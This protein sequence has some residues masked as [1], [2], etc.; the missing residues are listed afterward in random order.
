MDP[1]PLRAHYWVWIYLFFSAESQN[2]LSEGCLNFTEHLSIRE[3]KFK[4]NR[5][6]WRG[7]G[8]K[9]LQWGKIL[10]QPLPWTCPRLKADALLE[11][12]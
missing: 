5:L 3:L 10:W 11:Q 2:H 9:T 8:V 1:G 6:R 12:K 7:G 4:S